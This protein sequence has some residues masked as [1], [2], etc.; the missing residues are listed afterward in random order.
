M[1]LSLK[2]F[3]DTVSGGREGPHLKMIYA[4]TIVA[5]LVTG[6]NKRD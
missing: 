6:Y 3:N 2:Y 5:A 4:A 1:R